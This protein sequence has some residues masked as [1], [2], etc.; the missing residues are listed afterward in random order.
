MKLN[1]EKFNEVFSEENVPAN[2]NREKVYT[3]ASVVVTTVYEWI[4][5]L[6]RSCILIVV[7]LAFCFRLVNVDGS[8]MNPTLIDKDKVIVTNLFYEPKDGD[9]V[10]ISHG[11]I[12]DEPLVKRVIATAGQ[13]LN[14]DFT[15]GDVFVDGVLIEEKY[16]QGN[17]IQ[18]DHEIPSIIPEGKVFVMGDNREHSLDSRFEKVGLID[19]TSIIG[20]ASLVAFPFTNF[21]I[22]K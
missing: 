19:E 5:S 14:I 6:L 3:N 20:K 11:E 15:T 9:V 21:G 16:I 2:D 13:T 8:S 17:T 1:N 7:I 10:V 18:G 4:L 22:I 12:Y